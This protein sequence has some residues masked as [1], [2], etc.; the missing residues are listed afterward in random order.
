MSQVGGNDIP[1]IDPATGQMTGGF[2][3]QGGANPSNVSMQ[4]V[5]P[6]TGQPQSGS[7]FDTGVN[8]PVPGVPPQPIPAPPTTIT[9]D[10]IKADYEKSLGRDPG[11]FANGQVDPGEAGS[12]VWDAWKN[13][14]PEAAAA[15]IAASPEAQAY[16]KTGQGANAQL[17]GTGGFTNPANRPSG[18]AGL[19]DPNASA[20]FDMLKGRI[21]ASPNVDPNDPIIAAQSEAYNAQNTRAGRD[22]LTAA[23]E[24]GGPTA[25]LTA[26]NMS[27]AEN[28]AQQQ[29]GFLAQLQGDERKARRADIE[30]ALTTGA[31]FLTAEQQAKLQAQLQEMDT[32]E[33]AYEFDSNDRYR[34]SPFAA[35]A[36]A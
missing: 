15:A 10:Q 30:Q 25:N 5:T 12:F 18:S 7:P 36:G 16:A 34:Y 26:A 24:R 29:A 4:P 32:Q 35:G 9:G 2:T 8:P 31:Q 27:V 22:A 19:S 3:G 21:N 20:F 17:P 6:Q 1:Y 13:M 33:R 11:Q 14:T 28:S 23:A